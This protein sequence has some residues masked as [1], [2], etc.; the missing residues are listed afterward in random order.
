MP[1][2]DAPNG[3]GLVKDFGGHI[4]PISR[5]G[6]KELVKKDQKNPI[7]KSISLIIN[8]INLTIN[9]LRTTSVWNPKLLSSLTSFTQRNAQPKDKLKPKSNNLTDL[10]LNKLMKPNIVVK[11]P[12][13]NIIGQ[14][15]WST[16]WYGWYFI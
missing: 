12:Q 16:K 6:T 15:L 8:I 7:N 4:T 5:T 2:V 13:D 9:P 11:K 1:A 3:E 14:G 10:K